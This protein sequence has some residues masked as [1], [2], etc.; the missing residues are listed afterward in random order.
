MLLGLSLA[1]LAPATGAQE[2][3][4]ITPA[5]VAAAEKEGEFTLLYS[6]PLASMQGVVDDFRKAYPKIKVNME[7]KAGSSGASALLQEVSAGVNR[8]DVFQG[9]DMAANQALV[10]EKVCAAIVPA[11][12][13]DY[14]PSASIMA[15]YLYYPDV[16]STVVAYN[17]KFV[18]EAEAQKLRSWTGVLDPAFKGRI[19]V[20]EPVFG[21]TLAPLIYV[22]NTPGLGEDFLKKLK[23][24]EPLVYLNTAQAREAVV[25]GQ[26]PISW[27]AQWEAVMLADIDKGTPVRFVYPEPRVEWGGTS[28]GVLA[29]APHPNAA[30]LFIA[31]KFSKAGAV[32][33]Q[34]PHT[35]N[36]PGLKQFEDARSA[37]KTVQKESWFKMPNQV[38]SPDPKDWVKNG[39]TYQETWASIMKSR[40]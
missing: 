37:M 11:G 8:V 31:W 12:I 2:K 16:N 13:G 29:K 34:A 14:L 15:P 23:A 24:Q 20:V 3:I 28:Y 17:P 30:R 7:R 39:T 40:R 5:L 9:S 25:S 21:V 27:G 6:S 35:S 32:S 26:K 33:E 22:M 36:R 18:T 38:W 10:D 1:V 4:E 19:S